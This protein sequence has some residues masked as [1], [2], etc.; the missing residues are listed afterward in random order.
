YCR[1]VLSCSFM[2]LLWKYLRPHSTLIWLSL[3]LAGMEQL[4]NVIDAIFF[5]KSI[6]DYA[7]KLS[8]KPEK[9][10]VDGVLYW[11][12]I[13][14]G[15]AL[16]ARLSRSFQDY[17]MRLA[18]QKFGMQIFNDGL[19]QTLRLS[20]QEFEVQRSG[21]TLAVLQKVRTDTERFISSF[22]NVLFSSLVGFGFLIWY[23]ITKHWAL[24]PVFLIGFI[25]LGTFTGLLSRKIKTVQRSINRETTK[26]SGLITE[27]LRNIELVKSLG[28]TYPEV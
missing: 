18:V 26:M 17:I 8:K 1:F 21:E 14:I 25:V 13:A 3:L 12:A 10:L 23:A 19:K 2:K 15:V 11:L 5:G 22:I 4:L 7:G 27:S 28:L 9:E 20:F 24:V 16:L 6:D